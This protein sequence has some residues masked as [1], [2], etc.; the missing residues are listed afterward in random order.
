M[1]WQRAHGFYVIPRHYHG[2]TRTTYFW[3]WWRVQRRKEVAHA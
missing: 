3:L 1:Q 2:T